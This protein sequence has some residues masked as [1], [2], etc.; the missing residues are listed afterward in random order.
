MTRVQ[1]FRHAI[2][3]WYINDVPREI[4]HANARKWLKSVERLGDKWLFAKSYTT[5]EL[6]AQ[7]PQ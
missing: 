6:K 2:K 3:L 7:R 1:L 4:C 5:E